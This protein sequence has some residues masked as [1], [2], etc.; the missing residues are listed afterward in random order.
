MTGKA[1]IQ[2]NDTGAVVFRVAKDFKE[3][4]VPHSADCRFGGSGSR[5]VWDLGGKRYNEF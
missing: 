3:E 4:N 1:G 2:T 5:G